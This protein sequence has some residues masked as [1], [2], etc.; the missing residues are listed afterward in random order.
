MSQ[1]V[2][3]LVSAKDSHLVEQYEL[4]FP[5]ALFHMRKKE[6]SYFSFQGWLY[7]IGSLLA[8]MVLIMLMIH[9]GQQ[10]FALS[11]QPAHDSFALQQLYYEHNSLI[12]SMV[13]IGCL[14]LFGLFLVVIRVPALKKRR[15]IVC[16]DGLL[17]VHSEMWSN[18][19][20]VIRWEEIFALTSVHQSF[21]VRTYTHL[22]RK[23]GK[24]L[25]LTEKYEQFDELL[26]LIK[27]QRQGS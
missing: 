8:E 1:D 18:S 2:T 4:G 20:E 3:M 16:E 9:N 27:Q 25:V 13:V 11:A 23:K 22:V 26:A 15:V 14:F 10:I 17:Q 19:I 7:F 24:P 5:Q 12:S 21:P 6:I